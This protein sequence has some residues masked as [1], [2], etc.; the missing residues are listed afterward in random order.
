MNKEKPLIG[1]ISDLIDSQIKRFLPA[2]ISVDL[3]EIKEVNET[4]LNA[5]VQSLESQGEYFVDLVLDKEKKT[6]WIKPKVGSTAYVT[7]NN[8]VKF[9]CLYNQI[10]K[11]VIGDGANEQGVVKIKEQQDEINT[12]LK[13]KVNEIITFLNTLKTSYVAHTHTAPPAGGA[14]S[15]LI[16]PFTETPPTNAQAID[17]AN[18]ELQDIILTK[19]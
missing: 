3:V 2:T 9:F 13:D 5:K 17:K 1:V 4:D 16:V 14:T 19:Y 15:P 18:Y 10:E 11:I 12:K 7:S 8:G 6:A